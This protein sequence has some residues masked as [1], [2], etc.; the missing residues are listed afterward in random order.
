MRQTK[1][2]WSDLRVGTFILSGVAVIVFAILFFEP[3]R[4][5]IHETKVRALFAS[6]KGLVPGATVRMSGVEIGVVTNIRFVNP[7]SIPTNQ[8]LLNELKN[9]KSEMDRLNFKDPAEQEKYFRD[10]RTYSDLQSQVKHVSV[11]MEVSSARVPLIRSSSVALLKNVGLVGEKYVEITPSTADSAPL[12][13]VVDSNGVTALEVQGMEAPDINTILGNTTGFTHSLEDITSE[14]DYDIKHGRGTLG[15]L[16]AS[17]G[18]HDALYETLKASAEAT[19]YS[20]EL[21]KSIQAGKGSLGKL[22]NDPALYN[23]TISLLEKIQ[24]TNSTLGKMFHDPALYNNTNQAIARIGDLIRKVDEENGTLEKL[25]RDPSLYR[26]TN[27]AMKEFSSL[28]AD[29][30]SGKG[31]LGKFANDETLFVNTSAA[32]KNFA[33]V[34]EKL[35]KGDGSLGLLVQDKQ[36]YNNMT[37]VSSELLKLIQDIRKNPKKYLTVQMNVVKLF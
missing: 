22:F 28:L 21:L 5:F 13:P 32:M 33:A 23:S 26:N 14:L 30:N 7:A 3:G 29:A 8:E 16:I 24:S 10:E 25:I 2:T 35:N 1:V 36:L 12:S 19:Q 31:S 11:L 37:L 15:K 34:T 6:I 4:G 17:S 27:Q 20:G 18:V 9:V